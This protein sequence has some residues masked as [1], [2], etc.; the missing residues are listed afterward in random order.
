[1]KLRMIATVGA[2]WILGA[3]STSEVEPGLSG[4]STEG[5]QSGT[6]S[7]GEQAEVCV[8]DPGAKVESVAMDATIEELHTS[9]E[10]IAEPLRE[11]RVLA[12]ND[13]GCDSTLAIDIAPGSQATV[14]L[15]QWHFFEAGEDLTD[16]ASPEACA[17]LTIA[18]E[19]RVSSSDGTLVFMP[20]EAIA[21]RSSI[22]ILEASGH[23]SVDGV[24]Q[25]LDL[26]VVYVGLPETKAV[27]GVISNRDGEVI[28]SYTWTANGTPGT[29]GAGGEGGS[30]NDEVGGAAGLAED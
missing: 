20:T 10:A 26:T 14:A 15:G 6:D 29:G 2:L 25:E 27:D 30:G 28:R 21:T 18:V 9:A 4:P 1:M 3:C 22:A 17:R 13:A 8:I 24:E 12:C 16:G 5:G 23:G 19:A 11:P 7:S